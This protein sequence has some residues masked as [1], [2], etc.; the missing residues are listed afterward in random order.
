MKMLKKTWRTAAAGAVALLFSLSATGMAT[1]LEPAKGKPILVVSGS[2][3]NTNGDKGAEF[4]REMLEGLGTIT[5]K[6]MTPWFDEPV[7]FEGVPVRKV[8]AAAGAE[9]KEIV[10]VALNDYKASL[11][12]ADA[13][14]FDVILALKR[15]GEYMAVRDKGPLFIVYPF[16]SKPELQRQVYYGRSV[17]Q[18]AKLVVN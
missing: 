1:A 3:K 11:P 4:D 13:E 7:E 2:V 17:W 14:K 5:F 16:D 15:D 8:L 10:A 18:L 6:T 9:G 12:F